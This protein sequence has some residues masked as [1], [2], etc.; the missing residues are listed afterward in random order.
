MSVR[1]V[2]ARA[3]LCYL[4]TCRY[5]ATHVE[6]R[7]KVVEKGRVRSYRGE[8][9]TELPVVFDSIVRIPFIS[10]VLIGCGIERFSSSREVFYFVANKS[11]RQNEIRAL[12]LEV[13]LR[14]GKEW[15]E[16]TITGSGH[17][18]LLPSHILILN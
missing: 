5:P 15:G 11:A 10:S 3:S 18:R 9:P 16:P 1:D 12:L 8:T 13:E 4:H 2:L 17:S 7:A 6:G 14:S